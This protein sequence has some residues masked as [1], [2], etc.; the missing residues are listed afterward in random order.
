MKR[1][2]PHTISMMLVLCS[3]SVTFAGA[4]GEQELI[5]APSDVGAPPSDAK[6]RPFG[7]ATKVIE[8][9]SGTEH[10]GPTSQ[11]TVNYTGWTTDG[12]MFDGSVAQGLTSAFPLNR[13]IRDWTEGLQLM[14]EGEKRR[15]WIPEDLA[16]RGQPDRPQG[17]LVFDVEL[18]RIR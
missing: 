4:S 6:I 7:L 8:A 12:E 1:M 3:F 14:V 18:I 11:V 10:P 2:S 9:W 15:F 16:Y 17:M 5:P 13:V